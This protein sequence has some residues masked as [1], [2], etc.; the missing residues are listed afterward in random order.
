VRFVSSTNRDPEKAIA[1]G[2]LREDLYYRLAVVPIHVPALHERPEDI[3]LLAEHFASRYWRRH[4][5]DARPPPRLTPAALSE[6]QSRLWKG[7]V[8]ELQ[9]VVEHAIVLIG[10]RDE[11]DVADVSTV[12]VRTSG[13]LPNGSGSIV[14]GPPLSKYHPTREG[15]I[16]RFERE[17][18][19]CVLQQTEGNVSEAARVAGINRATLYRMMQRHGMTRGAIID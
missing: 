3:P 2:R 15:V 14:H 17:Y 5:G 19:T 1:D 16:E 18:L 13:D 9:N 10:D 8:R 6:L 12:S 7:N 4:R 11:I